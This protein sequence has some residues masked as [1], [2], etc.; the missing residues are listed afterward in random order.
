MEMN[1]ELEDMIIHTL[2]VVE[3]M[4]ILSLDIADVVAKFRDEIEENKNA[5]WKAVS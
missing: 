1:D 5:L 2:D 4:D 3:F